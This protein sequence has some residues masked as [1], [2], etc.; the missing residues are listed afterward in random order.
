MGSEI[1]GGCSAPAVESVPVIGGKSRLRRFAEVALPVAAFAIVAP[2]AV[3]GF[4][5]AVNNTVPT[6]EVVAIEPVGAKVTVE[7][8]PTTVSTTAIAAA[9]EAVAPAAPTVVSIDGLAADADDKTIS[10]AT[11]IVAGAP[12]APSAPGSAVSSAN[13]ESP[14]TADAS[15]SHSHGAITAEVALTRGERADL[16]AQLTVA[17]AAAAQFPTVG[18]AVAGGYTLITGY[19]PLIGAHY[20]KWGLLDGNF[21]PAAPEMLLYDGTEPDSNIVGLS[22]YLFSD[23]EPSPFVGAN[24][25]WHQHIGLCIKDGVVVG[26]ENTSIAECTERGGAKAGAT[27]GWMVHAWVVP[28]WDSPQGVFSPEHPGL[29]AELPTS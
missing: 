7:T 11:E 23:T 10:L 19:L 5:T 9:V 29:T 27:N 25:H 2:F 17:R 12:T 28:G 13:P 8:V 1:D 24:D 18:A 15:A 4:A 21:D 20:I 3:N 16:A 6:N 14:T 22:Y 26:G